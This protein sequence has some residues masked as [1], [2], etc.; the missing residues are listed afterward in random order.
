[1]RSQQ[2]RQNMQP[3]YMQVTTYQKNEAVA[4]STLRLHFVDYDL[5]VTLTVHVP[6]AF[7]IGQKWHRGIHSRTQNRV[8]SQ[9]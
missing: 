9:S 8:F 3:I 7:Q 2:T 1:M 5:D 4:Q 6:L